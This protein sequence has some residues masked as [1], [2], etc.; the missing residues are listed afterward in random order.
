MVRENEQRRRRSKGQCRQAGT[1]I[2][3]IMNNSA[4]CDSIDKMYLVGPKYLLTSPVI[5]VPD[6]NHRVVAPTDKLLPCDF[7]RH[8][9]YPLWTTVR[10]KHVSREIK[11]YSQCN[12]SKINQCFKITAA[13]GIECICNNDALNDFKSHDRTR[14]GY[15]LRFSPF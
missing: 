14:A 9:P 10:M 5:S 13:A 3:S 15:C 12:Q 7:Q 11:T 1:S 2:N 8:D 6:A 4:L